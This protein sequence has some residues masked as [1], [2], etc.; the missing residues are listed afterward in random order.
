MST[1]NRLA[2]THNPY[3]GDF[4]KVLCVCSA[5]LL[6]SPST[7]FVLS[8]DPFNFNTIAAGINEDYALI[9]V[10]KVL[11]EWSDVI[12]CMSDSQKRS[13]E[14]IMRT[15]KMT[16]K[17]VVSLD[18]PDSFAYRDPKLL[19]IIKIKATAVFFPETKS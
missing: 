18:I 12:V 2:N 1:M 17:D 13:V 4:K 9:V 7:A 5:G 11:I 16:G 8:Q 6:R 19:K 14:A 3:Q 10:D 15:L